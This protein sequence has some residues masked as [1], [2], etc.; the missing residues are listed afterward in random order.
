MFVV[1]CITGHGVED[2]KATLVSLGAS[3]PQYGELIPAS[4]LTLREQL[5]AEGRAVVCPFSRLE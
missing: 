2:L 3:L 5:Q 4:W 1:D